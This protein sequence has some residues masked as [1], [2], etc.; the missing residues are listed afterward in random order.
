MSTQVLLLHWHIC[1]QRNRA[2]E[3]SISCIR[4]FIILESRARFGA[5]IGAFGTIRSRQLAMYGVSIPRTLDVSRIQSECS[6]LA[7][8]SQFPYYRSVLP[9][10]DDVSEFPLTS[11]SINN[12]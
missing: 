12:S 8:P 2:S 1:N 10:M 3:V 9:S 4:S 11:D 7:L 5:T 6:N